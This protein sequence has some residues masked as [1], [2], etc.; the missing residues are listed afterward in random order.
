KAK[1]FL[2]KQFDKISLADQ[3]KE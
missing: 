2:M 3:F 1:E